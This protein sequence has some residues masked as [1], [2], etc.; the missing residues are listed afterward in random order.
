[1]I[2]SETT[3]HFELAKLDYARLGTQ[4][5]RLMDKRGEHWTKFFTIVSIP[6][7]AAGV[8]GPQ[9]AVYLLALVPF[10]LTCI[11]LEIKHD[12]QVLRYDVRKQMKLLAA[13][14]GF[15]NH[16]SK[17]ATSNEHQQ[18]RFWH[19]YYK[20]GR[21][22]AFIAVECIAS[23]IVWCYFAHTLPVYGIFISVAL[24]LLNAFFVLFTA[25]CML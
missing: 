5:Q 18:G 15:A 2:E 23:L 21:L 13:T 3:S 8:V 19:G 22:A 17:F 7:G 9:G 24:T 4:E 12:E 10:F 14:W 1:M 25:W 11:A 16:D 20:Q 6:G